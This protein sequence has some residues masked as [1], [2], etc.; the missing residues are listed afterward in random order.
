MANDGSLGYLVQSIL[1]DLHVPGIGAVVQRKACD[2]M[3]FCRDKKYFFSDR[4]LQFNLSVGRAAYR[5]GDGFGLPKDLVEISSPIIWILIGGSDDQRWPCHRIDNANFEWQKTSW[6]GATTE[7]PT[8]WAWRAGALTFVPTPNS[9]TDV[10]ELRYLSN[11]GVP[12]VVYE[13]GAYKFFHPTTGAEMNSTDLDNFSNDWLTHDN[14][15][16]MI[17]AR[18]MYEV[19]KNYL[20]DAEGANES[21][22]NW[23]EMVAQLENETESKQGGLTELPGCILD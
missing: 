12:R 19:Q 21:L 3:R 5:P 8:D 11:I 4:E 20:R 2:A 18:T 1:E 6:G 14:G 9:S 16:A 7:Q 15:A 23:L 13:G 17:R 22:G 10:A